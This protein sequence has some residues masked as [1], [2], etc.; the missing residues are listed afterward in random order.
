M[1]NNHRTD[2]VFLL[3]NIKYYDSIY[4]VVQEKNKKAFL[5]N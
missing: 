4:S 2:C 1:F 3:N 5:S